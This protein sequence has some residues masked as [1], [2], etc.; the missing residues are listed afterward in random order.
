[1]LSGIYQF[2]KVADHF[3]H[4]K[5]NLSMKRFIFY[6]IFFAVA[7]SNVGAQTTLRVVP[8]GKIYE[9]T[10]RNEAL[11]FDRGV[12][13]VFIPDGITKIRGIFIHQHGCTDEGHGASNAYDIQYQ[14]FAKKWGLV[15]VGP[16]LYPKPGSNCDG[17]RHP[18]EDGSGPSLFAAMEEVGKSSKHP[19]LATA[20]FL[21]WGHSGGGYWVLSMLD[22]YPKRIMAIV[23]YSPAFDPKFDYSDAATK[24]PLLIRHAGSK[25]FN[26]PGVDCWK[27]ALHSFSKLRGM[28]G[29]VSIAYNA[30]QNHNLS[31]LRYMAIP[32]FE[33]VLEQQF[34]AKSSSYRK[35][36]DQSKAW[37][38]DTTTTGKPKIYKA[39]TFTGNKLSMS[40]LPDSACAA[41]FSEF[42]ETNMV[43]D[44][45]PPF[46]PKKL[47]LTEKGDS[48]LVSW[49]ADA[50]IESGIR[51]FNIYK[52]GQFFSRYP[53]DGDFQKFDTNGDEPL[54]MIP[55]VMVFRFLK[56]ELNKNDIIEITTVN[57][58]DL[59]S[60]K[61]KLKLK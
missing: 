5:Y 42:V 46:P 2:F 24:V 40:W 22:N 28:D 37:L 54:P 17:W 27:T 7:C 12:Y 59:E 19:E 38:C 50:D 57:R 29:Q 9:T 6:L 47:K 34:S 48:V 8:G 15:V 60:G 44:V 13:T 51:C 30:G 55:P 33:S 41:K 32:F 31:F 39:S 25:D 35:E 1:M 18:V 4:I 10:I 58:F 52:N 61:T 23:A 14:A 36:M 20:P 16:D 3:V 21:F 43:R 49:D 45:T 26:D 53:A 56:G 11:K